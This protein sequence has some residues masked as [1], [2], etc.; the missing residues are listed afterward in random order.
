[1][2]LRGRVSTGDGTLVPNDVI[3]ERI[4]SGAV[5]QQV[6][7]S[8]NGDFSM[9]LGSRDNT[10]IDASGDGGSMRNSPLG[11]NINNN[12]IL[13][14]PKRDLANCELRASASG[15]RS[16]AKNLVDLD[17][18]SGSVDVGVL[19]VDRV[20]R[21]QGATLSATPYK[22]PKEAWKAYEKG[23]EAEKNK[24]FAS[25]QKYF[26]KAVAIFPRYAIAWYELGGILEKEKQKEEA[27]EAYTKAATID[28][29]FLP[30]FLSLASLAYEA[31]EWTDVLDLTARVEDLDPW[32]HNSSTGYIVD[33][34]RV[35][36]TQI[37]FYETVANY[38]LNKMAA[39]EKSGLKAEQ[40]M[41]VGTR[42]PQLHLVMA[43]IL[44]RRNNYSSAI[45]ELETYLQLVPHANN[46][47]R[48]R[49]ELA[50]MK[51]MK[52]STATS[53]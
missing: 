17:V 53:E 42:Y 31:G 27:R 43:Q 45:S 6:Y 41:D 9:E 11:K 2:F 36:Y 8:L 34:D 21:I 3:V 40:Y 26:E 24:K 35:N 20:A 15:F 19:V 23:L 14:I 33:F 18:T 48:V 39:A 37:Y 4:C 52:D 28:F 46:M 50:K 44:A 32:N 47:D 7:A 25:A 29:K 13:G 5:R 38:K 51:Q 22:A 10:L 30:P 49:A 12:S 16:N 1:M